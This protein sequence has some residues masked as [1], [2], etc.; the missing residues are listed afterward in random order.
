MLELYENMELAQRRLLHDQ[1]KSVLEKELENSEGVTKE[2]IKSKL[3]NL[4]D[5]YGL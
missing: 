5:T 1:V 2:Q 3:D 4:S